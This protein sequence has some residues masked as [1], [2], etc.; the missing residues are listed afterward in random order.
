MFD[1]LIKRYS[2]LREAASDA[3]ISRRDRFKELILSTVWGK[4]VFLKFRLWLR[5]SPYILVVLSLLRIL[6]F[7]EFN[8]KFEIV[9]YILGNIVLFYILAKE[10][11][12][13]RVVGYHNKLFRFIAGMGFFIDFTFLV[14]ERKETN[15]KAKYKVFEVTFLIDGRKYRPRLTEEVVPSILRVI[16]FFFVRLSFLYA[17][18]PRL[19]VG[20]YLTVLATFI[21]FE[22]MLYVYGLI[23]LFNFMKSLMFSANPKVVE[24]VWGVQTL[25]R[26]RDPKTKKIV[27]LCNIFNKIDVFLVFFFFGLQAFARSYEKKAQNEKGSF[28]ECVKFHNELF[29]NDEEFDRW[30]KQWALSCAFSS[31]TEK[32]IKSEIPKFNKDPRVCDRWSKIGTFL[33][34]ISFIILSVK[35]LYIF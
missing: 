6:L 17:Y 12:Y 25:L 15:A 27:A 3:W 11:Y 19:F 7:L 31:L 33:I 4:E 28:E 35:I 22:S 20:V 9:Y 24:N 8:I 14:Q 18:E 32:E 26:G 29:E 34:V 23:L 2:R 1:L 13:E 30:A 5:I 10:N 21:Y 16:Y